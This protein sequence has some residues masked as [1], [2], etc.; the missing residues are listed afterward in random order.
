MRRVIYKTERGTKDG[1]GIMWMY[2]TVENLT[3]FSHVCINTFCF[4]YLLPHM[5]LDILPSEF[6]MKYVSTM[7]GAERQFVIYWITSS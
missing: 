1:C 7:Y 6:L 2:K 3:L 4:S 5:V